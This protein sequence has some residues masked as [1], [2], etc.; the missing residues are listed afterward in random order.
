MNK[1]GVLELDAL[2]A[3]KGNIGRSTVKD[4]RTS[5]N[6]VGR[7]YA[8]LVATIATVFQ[9]DGP[10]DEEWSDATNGFRCDKRTLLVF[11]CKTQQSPMLEWKLKTVKSRSLET[12]KE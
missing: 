3:G 9:V 8:G 5:R 11:A 12:W 7:R 1:Y 6:Q 4:S 10:G 2:I